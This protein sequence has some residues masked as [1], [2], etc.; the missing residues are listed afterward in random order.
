M[1]RVIRTTE[2][3]GETEENIGTNRNRNT[4]QTEE[5]EAKSD[6]P[7]KT[8]DHTVELIVG[9]TD[10]RCSILYVLSLSGFSKKKDRT[11]RLI[12]YGKGF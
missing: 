4:Y 3:D 5:Q 9:H 8:G 10:I 1:N 6:Q 2:L 11:N 7:K 12:I